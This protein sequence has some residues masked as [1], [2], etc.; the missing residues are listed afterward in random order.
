MCRC[1]PR[2]A[3]SSVAFGLPS[4]VLTLDEALSVPLLVVSVSKEPLTLMP[5]HDGFFRKQVGDARKRRETDDKG[6]CRVR[7][8]MVNEQTSEKSTQINVRC[9]A[10][11]HAQ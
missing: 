7:S 11:L 4:L 10:L 5:L 2:T 9:M 3:S 6:F 8:F 1:I